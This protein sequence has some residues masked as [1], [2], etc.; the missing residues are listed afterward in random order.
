MPFFK[1]GGLFPIKKGIKGPPF[2]FFKSQTKNQGLE[3][4]EIKRF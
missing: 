1:L 2:I 4:L 3:T